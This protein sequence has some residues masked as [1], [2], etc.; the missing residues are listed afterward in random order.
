MARTADL[1]KL[2][3]LNTVSDRER[4]TILACLAKL[5]TSTRTIV[6]GEDPLPEAFDASNLGAVKEVLSRAFVVAAHDEKKRRD[7]RKSGLLDKLFSHPAF[8]AMMGTE[9]VKRDAMANIPAEVRAANPSIQ[10]PTVAKIDM[11]IVKLAI[12][13]AFPGTTDEQIHTDLS[14]MKLE[15]E[16]VGRGK[17]AVHV[18][19]QVYDAWTATQKEKATAAS[20]TNGA[21]K[22]KES[23]ATA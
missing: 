3:V 13:S 4:E 7:N 20:K 14:S 1:S 9:I 11:A 19:F 21:S 17:L 2:P 22:G 8:G 18:P 12:L 5:H 10:V 23:A 16:N 6:A 15:T